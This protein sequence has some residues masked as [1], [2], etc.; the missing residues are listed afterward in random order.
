MAILQESLP[1]TF[2]N[3]IPSILRGNA[4]ESQY[5]S[6]LK[7]SGTIYTTTQVIWLND[8][9]NHPAYSGLLGKNKMFYVLKNASKDKMKIDKTKKETKFKS[10]FSDKGKFVIDQQLIDFFNKQ[11]KTESETPV[12]GENKTR[13]LNEI[14]DTIIQDIENLIEFLSFSTP[15]YKLILDVTNSIR[16]RYKIIEDRIVKTKDIETKL[17]R[18]IKSIGE[19]N[20]IEVIY[21]KYLDNKEIVLDYETEDETVKAELKSKYGFYITFV[22][23]LKEFIRPA[24][25]STNP[26]LQEIL[27]DFSSGT[28]NDNFEFLMKPK[29]LLESEKSKKIIANTGISMIP[30]TGNDPRLEVHVQI[31]CIEGELND[32]NKSKINCIYKGAYLGNMLDELLY[33]QK[34]SWEL[35]KKRM[36]FNINDK[37]VQKEIK[38]KEAVLPKPPTEEN[39]GKKN[40][41]APPPPLQAQGGGKTKKYRLLPIY[42]LRSNRRTRRR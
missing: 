27:E 1:F 4:Y 22:D 7:I 20:T 40:E 15:K 19:L 33:P 25:E 5:Y 29:T 39:K 6:Y 32:E 26:E 38:E 30:I 11:K 3:A 2:K 10:D 13:E 8:V 36:F 28:K 23:S 9:Y 18:L 17:N 31:D 12:Y 37:E 34:T 41:P 16:Q 35:E 24:R 21:S 42:K 14:I